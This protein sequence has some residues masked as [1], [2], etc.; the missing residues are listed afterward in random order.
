M[1]C[2]YVVR[3]RLF[4]QFW[5]DFQVVKSLGFVLDEVVRHSFEVEETVSPAL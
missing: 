4:D 3:Q 1:F 5:C 2:D